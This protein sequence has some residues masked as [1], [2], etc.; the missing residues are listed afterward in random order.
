METT[1]KTFTAHHTAAA[2]I[3][4]IRRWSRDL[5]IDDYQAAWQLER[6]TDAQRTRVNRLDI[7]L[8][9]E[10]E[11]AG[12]LIAQDYRDIQAAVGGVFEIMPIPHNIHA[13]A[14]QSYPT[15]FSPVELYVDEEYLLKINSKAEAIASYN[16]IASELYAELMRI[17][18]PGMPR[19]MIQPIFGNAM[20]IFPFPELLT[21]QAT[22]E[23]DAN[24]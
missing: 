11:R 7:P 2:C 19:H 3:D 16:T 10:P 18:N 21:G 22:A 6:L 23:L 9:T 13:N 20:I 12:A 15:S 14:G 24:F 4:Y 5:A 17:I 1:Q 8:T